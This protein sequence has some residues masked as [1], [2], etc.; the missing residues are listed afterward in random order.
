M[1]FQWTNEAS[2]W[3]SF[4][5]LSPP[6]FS[7]SPFVP[8]SPQ[9]LCVHVSFLS[10]LLL[11]CPL[12]LFCSPVPGSLNRSSN[13]SF[14][15]LTHSAASD[16]SRMQTSPVFLLTN[17]MWIYIRHWNYNHERDKQ[18]HFH[19][20]YIGRNLYYIITQS[21]CIWNL[22]MASCCWFKKF[23]MIQTKHLSGFI[24]QN[25]LCSSHTSFPWLLEIL[26]GKVLCAITIPG[27]CL[28]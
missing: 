25:S 4:L 13:S 8:I 20:A 14:H 22:S 18:F 19:R 23:F 28:L 1:S 15:M 7:M 26:W 24:S 5:I 21:Y 12:S 17:G 27:T 3:K 16:L 10:A 9:M 6:H 2:I 11:L